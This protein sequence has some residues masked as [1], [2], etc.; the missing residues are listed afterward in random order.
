MYSENQFMVDFTLPEVLSEE[1]MNLIPTQRHEVNKLFIEGILVNYM[2]SLENAKLWAVFSAE[3]EYEVLQIIEALP[4]TRFMTHQI[5]MLT[6][7]NTAPEM[8][9]S[10]SMN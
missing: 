10:F 4:L 6:F 5:S 7:N 9:P 2:L 8:V 3:S 1:F